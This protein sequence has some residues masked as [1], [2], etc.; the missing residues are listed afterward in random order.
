LV[1]K[2]VVEEVQ[3]NSKAAKKEE[4]KSSKKEMFAAE[5]LKT[6]SNLKNI[7]QLEKDILYILQTLANLMLMDQGQLMRTETQRGFKAS[8]EIADLQGKADNLMLIKLLNQIKQQLLYPGHSQAVE[9]AFNK[10][11]KLE[12]AKILKRNVP[13]EFKKQLQLLKYKYNELL[14][15]KKNIKILVSD[16]EKTIK[17][18]HAESDLVTGMDGIKRAANFNFKNQTSPF[19]KEFI[20][21]NGL[22]SKQA[23]EAVVSDKFYSKTLENRETRIDDLELQHN[24][25]KNM[26]NQSSKLSDIKTLKILKD[27]DAEAFREST[28]GKLDKSIMN[29]IVKKVDIDKNTTTTQIKINLK[30]ETLGNVRMNIVS[31]NGIVKVSFIVEN[32]LVKDI[33]ENNLNH[34]KHNLQNQ[35]VAVQEFSVEVDIG[36]DSWMWDLQKHYKYNVRHN[37]KLAGEALNNM[38]LNVLMDEYSSVNLFV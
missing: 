25:F 11:V 8:D 14:K 21:K 12:N 35:G 30:P 32:K 18:K 3:I 28:I 31:E 1:V 16:S 6:E 20:S 5:I 2:E 23:S 22:S 17:Q 33:I 26:L 10:I 19:N 36:Q 4:T 24:P 34:L 38:S 27:V 7:K 13:D 9:K 15:E 29:Q 37:K